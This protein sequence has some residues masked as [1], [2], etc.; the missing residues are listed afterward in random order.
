MAERDRK[1]VSGSDN[2]AELFS[3]SSAS[4]ANEAGHGPTDAK[5]LVDP[6]PSP[7]MTE[8]RADDLPPTRAPDVADDF[9]RRLESRWATWVDGALGGSEAQRRRAATAAARVASAGG[10]QDE[11][12]QAANRAWR[13]AGLQPATVARPQE[14]PRFDAL[15]TR[16]PSPPDP[17]R[18]ERAGDKVLRGRVSGFQS[19]S[20]VKY[21]THWIPPSPGAGGAPGRPPIPVRQQMKLTVWT[22]FVRP[23]A[24]AANARG[25]EVEMKGRR[26]KGAI[27]DGDEVAIEATPKPGKTL[28]IKRLENLTT[29]STVR[30]KGGPAVGRMGTL[31]TIL[32]LIVF[33]AIAVAILLVALRGVNSSSF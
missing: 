17:A 8:S 3:G 19:N 21:A 5:R 14:P 27:A 25:V 15:P 28:R 11:A 9:D 6:G 7:G 22:F 20:E 29:G 26:F 33:V 10:T 24:G 23:D 12:M 32:G 16:T 2:I 30:A 1:I 4:S 18:H 13:E 31:V